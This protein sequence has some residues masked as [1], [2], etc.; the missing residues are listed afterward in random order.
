VASVMAITE[1]LW[2]YLVFS[3]GWARWGQFMSIV[4]YPYLKVEGKGAFLKKSLDLPLDFIFTSLLMIPLLLIQYFWLKSSLE[5]III[6]TLIGVILSLLVGWWFYHQ[7]NGH[8]GD[9]YGATVEWSEV[10]M[11]TCISIV[12]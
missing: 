4:L 11:L 3:A 8:T 5:L 2:F 9:T 1:N 6:E 10:L 7:L 12:F